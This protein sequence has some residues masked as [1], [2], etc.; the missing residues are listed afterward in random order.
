MCIRDR[1]CSM[2]QFQMM[3]WRAQAQQDWY[4]RQYHDQELLRRT[5][6]EQTCAPYA[7][8]WGWPSSSGEICAWVDGGGHQPLRSLPSPGWPPPPGVASAEAWR[9]QSLGFHPSWPHAD[10]AAT[11]ISPPPGL[12]LPQILPP[13][14]P[15]LDLPQTWSIVKV[16]IE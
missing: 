12:D 8:G 10:L 16:V 11:Q 1:F 15:G 13:P 14:P 4:N 2:T 9:C 3:Q 7:G 6:S 5:I